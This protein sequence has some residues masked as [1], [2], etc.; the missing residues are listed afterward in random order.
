MKPRCKLTGTDGNVFAL[1]GRVSATLKQAGQ[2]ADA[3]TMARR[4]M[5]CGSYA[6]AL[7]IFMEYVDVH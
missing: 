6:E 2:P 1:I 5:A 7:R 4:I 3:T